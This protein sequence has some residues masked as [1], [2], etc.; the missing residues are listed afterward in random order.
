M[1]R[2]LSLLDAGQAISRQSG[3]TEGERGPSV[4][5][6]AVA[7]TANQRARLT[8]GYT[9]APSA[10]TCAHLRR[11]VARGESLRSIARRACLSPQTV[12][13]IMTSATI[14]SSTRDAILALH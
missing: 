11:L 10:E 7:V 4:A 3:R 14:A 13:S 8:R 12:A 9:R 1:V 6:R 5:L 2:R